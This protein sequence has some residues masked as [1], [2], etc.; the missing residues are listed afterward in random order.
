M[1]V[2]VFYLPI[3]SAL[4]IDVIWDDYLMQDYLIN[5]PL[6]DSSAFGYRNCSYI[7]RNMLKGLTYTYIA[8][9]FNVGSTFR[10]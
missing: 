2:T 1:L 8:T 9:H 10:V 3:V 4:S 5:L 6:T 7:L